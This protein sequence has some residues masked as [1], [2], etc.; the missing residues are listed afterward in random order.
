[1][2]LSDAHAVLAPPRVAAV[3]C[4]GCLFLTCDIGSSRCSGFRFQL[5]A[6]ASAPQ[7]C[8]AHEEFLACY[9]KFALFGVLFVW[10]CLLPSFRLF[11]SLIAFCV[12]QQRLARLGVSWFRYRDRFCLPLF[13]S[14]PS[15]LLPLVFVLLLDG[16]MPIVVVVFGAVCIQTISFGFM[17]P[18][19]ALFAS[20]LLLVVVS[21]C[22]GG[23]SGL[24]PCA[25]LTA[26]DLLGSRQWRRRFGIAAESFRRLV[27]SA[28]LRWRRAKPHL[29]PYRS[30]FGVQ[31]RNKYIQT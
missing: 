20:V 21:C 18:A 7:F 22:L 30:S 24:F 8:L 3:L 5:H 19:V 28:K 29:T 27:G 11:C 13:K 31:P 16:V 23:V 17:G 4:L 6:I 25:R 14:S 9:R 26:R 12:R 2:V 15:R 10:Q 1:M